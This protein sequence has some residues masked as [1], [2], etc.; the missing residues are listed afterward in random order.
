MR[1]G[2]FACKIMKDTIAHKY[3]KKSKVNERHRHRYEVNNRFKEVIESQGGV[4]S[5]I[6]EQLDL[7]EIF[8]IKDHPFY[9]ASQFHPEFASRPLAP[10]PLFIGFIAAA[11]NRSGRQRLN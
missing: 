6:N 1:L 2:S 4:F 5:G 10:H 7:V 8:E 11:K 3:Y 9:V